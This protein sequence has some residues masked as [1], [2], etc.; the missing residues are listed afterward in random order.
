[1]TDDILTEFGIPPLLLLADI[2]LSSSPPHTYIFVGCDAKLGRR[3]SWCDW[4]SN[5]RTKLPQRAE[6]LCCLLALKEHPDSIR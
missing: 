3:K 4:D 6:T 5:I 2:S 1:M